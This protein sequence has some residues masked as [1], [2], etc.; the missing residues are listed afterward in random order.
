M[1]AGLKKINPVLFCWLI[2]NYLR[3]YMAIFGYLWQ[4]TPYIAKDSQRLPSF[5]WRQVGS[6][7]GFGNMNN[8]SGKSYIHCRGYKK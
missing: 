1:G 6:F 3:K 8:R 4:S 5:L 2:E 7:W